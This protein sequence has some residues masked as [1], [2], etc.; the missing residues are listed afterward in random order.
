MRNGSMIVLKWSM[1]AS[2]IAASIVSAGVRMI[3]P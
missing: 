2:R 3:S 1:G